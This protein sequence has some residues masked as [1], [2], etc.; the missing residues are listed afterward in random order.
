MTMSTFTR[1]PRHV[2]IIPDG[3][4]RW[5]EARGISRPEGY[6]AGLETGVRLFGLLRQLGIEEV[7]VYG[8]TKENV[9]RPLDQVEAF[10]EACA[11]MGE[12]IVNAGAAFLAVGD[13]RSPLFPETLRQYSAERSPG[14]IRFNLLVNYGWQ[15]DLFSAIERARADTEISY[16]A[17]PQVLGSGGV[18]RVD[19][20]VRWGGHRRLS[21]FLPVQ[22]AYADVHVVETLW[23]DAR[24]EDFLEALAWY[25]G[26]DV[27][28]GG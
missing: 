20:V 24:P 16:A 21:G 11:R 15:W 26:Q 19:L 12:F 6:A 10:R 13:T 2:G 27:T 18:S 1:L 3:N 14:D 9:R 8:F 22:C 4:R 23:P 5:A 7:S 25:Q 28:L 17:L